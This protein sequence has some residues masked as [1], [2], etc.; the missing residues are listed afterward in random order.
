MYVC[1]YIYT[2]Y[3]YLYIYMIYDMHWIYVWPS[4]LPTKLKRQHKLKES[5]FKE[6][7]W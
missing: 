7:T 5:R 4:S 6:S 2:I 3:M 1:M